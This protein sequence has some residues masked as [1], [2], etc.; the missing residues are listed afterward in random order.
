[1]IVL[2]LPSSCLINPS[3]TTRKTLL[4]L[5]RGLQHPYIH[6]VLDIEFWEIGAGIVT[7]LNPAGSLK[8]L[9]H[10]SVWHEEYGP[11]YNKRGSGLP[12]GT[13]SN[14]TKIFLESLKQIAINVFFNIFN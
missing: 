3:Q 5:F 4:E 9:I 6:P 10:D 12:L 1:M 8:D 14:S 2:P 13:V 7:P 11:K